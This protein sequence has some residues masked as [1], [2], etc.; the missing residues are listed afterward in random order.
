MLAS[1]PRELNRFTVEAVPGIDLR[2]QIA[3]AII[4][5]GWG[6]LEM[7][8]A[9]PS[10]EEIFVRLV[11]T[12]ET[13]EPDEDEQDELTDDEDELDEPDENP[14]EPPASSVNLSKEK[15]G[16]AE[17]KPAPSFLQKT[18][19]ELDEPAPNNTFNKKNKEK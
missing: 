3:A 7:R 10:L 18:D 19:E 9:V 12:D 17:A 14:A 6:L 11:N 1:E 5:Q 2:E 8:T 15:Q 4:G 16:K 13:N